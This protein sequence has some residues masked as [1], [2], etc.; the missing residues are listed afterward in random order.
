MAVV[1]CTG[2]GVPGAFMSMIGNS[3]LNEIVNNQNKHNPARILQLMHEGIR[4]RLM[5]EETSNRDGMDVCLCRLEYRDDDKIELTFSGAKRPIFLV[6]EGEL[7]KIHGSIE[8]IGGWLEGMQRDFE[9]K[10]IELEKNDALYL[11]SDGFAD[12]ANPKRKKFGEKRF[13][14]MLIESAHL[15]MDEQRQII[16]KALA[17][18]QQDTEQRDDITIVGI[19][20]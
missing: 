19:R 9:N 4:T 6:R 16:V 7:K 8:S 10:T 18:H 12:S 11:T 15:P 3:L 5:Q 14:K 20:V 2:H 1:D 17:D 13:R